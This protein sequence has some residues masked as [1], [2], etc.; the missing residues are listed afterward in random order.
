MFFRTKGPVSL[1]TKNVKALALD[2]RWIFLSGSLLTRKNNASYLVRTVSPS[3]TEVRVFIVF[4]I[5]IRDN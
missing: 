2:E 4:V 1:L 3:H 5:K